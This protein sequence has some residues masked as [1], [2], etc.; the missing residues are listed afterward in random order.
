MEFLVCLIVV[1]HGRLCDQKEAK[2]ESGIEIPNGYTCVMNRWA[3]IGGLVL[4]TLAIGQAQR[5]PVM[6][7][8]ANRFL[9]SLT[10][11]QKAKAAKSFTD[12]Y[13]THWQYVP[14]SRQGIN[15]SDMT[16]EQASN[17]IDLLKAS[18]SDSG[19][20]KTEVIKSL[21]LVLRALENGNKG[22]DPGIYTFTF[23]GEPTFDKVWGWR[24]EGH[25]VSLNFTFKGG[26]MISSTP[27]FFGSNPA[28]VRSGPQKGL[29]ALPQEEDLG[30]AL[31]DSLS[32]TQRTEAIL[33]VKAPG[34]VVTS[35]SRKAA[36]QDDSGISFK[37]LDSKQR[38][39][40]LKLVHAYSDNQ[41]SSESKRRWGR[42][43]QDSLVFAWMGDT[44]PG[45]PHYYRIQG[46]KFLI[47]FDNTQ[48]D[49]NHIHAVWRDFDGDF[50]GDL[51]AEHYA[52]SH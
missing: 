47:E 36:I 44:K 28:E 14:A 1:G 43:N 18:L 23:F 15:F 9:S 21:E 24:Y 7:V 4:M 20:K 30:Y 46:S 39:L 8:L 41:A 19:Y 26:D 25:H 33:P 45:G 2:I 38:A 22:R 13:R 50:G 3:F 6:P 12:D 48:N 29:R 5:Q 31:L 16:P 51:L 40:L 17:A 35:S 32:A 42:V 37:K 27:Q 10:A 11:D 52:Q 34:D 49:A